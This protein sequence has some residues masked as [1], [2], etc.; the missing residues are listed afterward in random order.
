MR[1]SPIRV[2]TLLSVL[3]VISMTGTTAHGKQGVS[4]HQE[5][6]G[7][8]SIKAMNERVPDFGARPSISNVRSGLW[9]NPDTW[10]DG[11]IPAAEDI[12]RIISGSTVIYDINSAS[13]IDTV[14]I[15]GKLHFSVDISTRLLVSQIM[16]YPSGILE[17][18]TEQAPIENSFR[19]EIVFTNR[20]LK[21]GTLDQPGLDPHQYGLG[22][23]VWGT[24]LIHGTP[25]STNYERLS[26]PAQAGDVY[27]YAEFPADWLPGDK[28]FMPDSRPI[29]SSML[30]NT[31]E[32]KH[33][34]PDSSGILIE[35]HW[36]VATIA[37]NEGN[38]IRLIKP[39]QY[40][41]PGVSGSEG[42][43]P[44]V[45]HISRNVVF[46]SSEPTGTRGHTIFFRGAKINVAYSAFIDLGRTSIDPLDNTEISAGG[47]LEK[48]GS[49]EIARYPV[50]LHHTTDP[51][52]ITDSTNRFRLIGNVIRGGKRWGL[53][54]HGSHFGMIQNNVVLDIKGAG[55]V[56]ENGSE[57]GNHFDHN[58][59]AAIEGSG[60]PGDY[61][62]YHREAGKGHGHEG[63]AY[64]FAS[65]YNM[66]TN[67]IAAG[68][69]NGGFS[70]FRNNS[71]K[72]EPT[73]PNLVSERMPEQF[74][75]ELPFM[76]RFSGNEA[77][78]TPGAGIEIWSTHG[79]NLCKEKRI[80]EDN[81][82]W[83][84]NTGINFDYHS[85]YYSFRGI[86]LINSV[87]VDRNSVGVKIKGSTSG[88]VERAE[89]KN[90]E[91]GVEGGGG[92]NL[93]FSIL[94]SSIVANIG[95]KINPLKSWSTKGKVILNDVSVTF[96]D[97]EALE[98][99]MLIK[100]PD[101]SSRN[102]HVPRAIYRPI[103]VKNFQRQ[104]DY[105]F[106]LFYKYQEPNHPI[107]QHQ[108]KRAGC[109]EDGLLNK[110]CWD[111]YGI[112]LSGKV[113]PCKVRI[114]G[115]DGYVCAI[116]E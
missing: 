22:L 84:F 26:I 115:V 57:T 99:K 52:K 90:V 108:D 15:A 53:V 62:E 32:A 95:V 55:I 31:E 41:H 67:N 68:F 18:G 24:L 89:I 35:Q 106:E 12:V 59:V 88:T 70:L 49:N 21:T 25:V 23:L 80:L 43:L 98:H 13:Q 101:R 37:S 3:F 44:H 11:K 45:A 75:G 30:G 78:G 74:I 8:P 114:T 87:P 66:I 110:Q 77:Y 19:A 2:I 54:V 91:I 81:I 42:L 86:Q 104:T 51:S 63:A 9:S 96:P 65:D 61:R 79:C 10:S 60:L 82:V 46:R 58:F 94:D 111:K 28:L 39:L 48:I 76:F 83:H 38:R 7:G 64:W 29:P 92:K 113:A 93:S 4:L 102:P 27:L 97:K 85:E 73:F 112:A 69:R 34:F 5:T 47:Q 56:T 107:Q 36:E 6:G 40:S 14:G 103:L 71:T 17:I 50:H 72:D 109:P 1:K 20:P 116:E 33:R 105:N 100:L 16:V